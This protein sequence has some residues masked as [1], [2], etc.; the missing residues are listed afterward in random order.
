MADLMR[1]YA[2]TMTQ[3]KLS[4]GQNAEAT[5]GLKELAELN[6]RITEQS[7]ERRGYK[8]DTRARRSGSQQTRQAAR[9]AQSMSLH[10]TPNVT[11]N[12]LSFPDDLQHGSIQY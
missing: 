9:Q 2:E 7:A 3:M 5:K 1:Q 12:P 8:E 10:T 4:T 6:H 11:V